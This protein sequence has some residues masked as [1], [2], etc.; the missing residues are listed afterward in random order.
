MHYAMRLKA[1]GDSLLEVLVAAGFGLSAGLSAGS[2]EG[3]A[4]TASG[5]QFVTVMPSTAAVG[6]I[7]FQCF[8][9]C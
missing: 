3:A 5:L 7:Q 1:S 8:T 9:L 2:T 6:L 4:T